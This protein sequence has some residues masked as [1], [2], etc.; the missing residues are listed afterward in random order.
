MLAILVTSYCLNRNDIFS[1]FYWTRG[2]KLCFL[3]CFFYFSHYFLI[4]VFSQNHY[5]L[6][7]LRLFWLH[8]K[9]VLVPFLVLLALRASMS[10]MRP[11]NSGTECVGFLKQ[12]AHEN[13]V[14]DSLPV[15]FPSSAFCQRFLMQ[16]SVG[17][18]Q[19]IPSYSQ[20]ILELTYFC[21]T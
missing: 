11:H 17:R 21:V 20:K 12:D 15:I 10:Y 2:I 6:I 3:T 8:G 1:S 13:L 18:T 5:S 9:R 14:V 19:I 4:L 7:S 16:T